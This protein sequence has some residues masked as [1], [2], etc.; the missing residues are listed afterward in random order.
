MENDLSSLTREVYPMPDDV[1]AAMVSRGVG[2][3]T[4]G[5]PRTS[6]TT[7]S[8]GSRAP[9]GPRHGRSGWS[10]CSMSSKGRRLHAHALDGA[11]TVDAADRR[12]KRCEK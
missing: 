9:S 4:I 2:R 1:A 6:A 5:D 7:M 3:H 11:L 12:G 10:R 8:A